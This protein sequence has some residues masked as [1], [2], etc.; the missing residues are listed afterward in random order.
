MPFTGG[1]FRLWG[2][3]QLFR[4]FLRPFPLQLKLKGDIRSAQEGWRANWGS[5]DTN[6]RLGEG[7]PPP[8]GEAA[9]HSK[10][11]PGNKAELW[12]DSRKL[13]ILQKRTPRSPG[14]CL[15]WSGSSHWR[16]WRSG[17]EILG[18]DDGGPRCKMGR[19]QRNPSDIHQDAGSGGQP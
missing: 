13:I 2:W 3:G 1:C 15:G 6:R 16:V 10:K 8:P 9:V 11:V 4:P 12:S 17:L 14:L 18:G 5:E 19:S 7:S